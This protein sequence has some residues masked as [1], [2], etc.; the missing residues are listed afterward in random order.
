MELCFVVQCSM[1]PSLTHAPDTDGETAQAGRALACAEAGTEDT[2]S[3]AVITLPQCN[4]RLACSWPAVKQ[5][6]LIRCGQVL[7]ELLLLQCTWGL[8]RAVCVTA[9]TSGFGPSV[10]T[11]LR[12][13]Q[14]QV[15]LTENYLR[16]SVA[17][18]FT[19]VVEG[20]WTCNDWLYAERASRCLK[21]VQNDSCR[22]ESRHSLAR[23]TS[24][25][26]WG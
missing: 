12:R 15:L 8:V 9:L 6:S 16:H 2:L 20:P 3:V 18:A 14:L 21:G 19:R 25:S 17:R 5:V 10:Q 26:D 11:Y 22:S 1:H 13:Q 4:V 7:H 24:C 23:I